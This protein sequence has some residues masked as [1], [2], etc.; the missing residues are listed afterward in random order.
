MSLF[1]KFVTIIQHYA[2]QHFKFIMLQ[3]HIS[4]VDHC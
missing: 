3:Q 4:L 2:E 1:L